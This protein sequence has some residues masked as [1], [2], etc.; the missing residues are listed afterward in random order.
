LER[1]NAVTIE[2]TC[3][4]GRVYVLPEDK[5]G[6]KLQ[7]RRCGAVIRVRRDAE[8]G[9]RV[10]FKALGIDEE[11][12]QAPGTA[13]EPP[14]PA[15]LDFK[16]PLRR[17]P[18][19]GNQD[20]PTVPVC[21]RCEYDFRAKKRRENP[22]ETRAK[23]ELNRQELR[24]DGRVARIELFSRLGFIP[25]AGIPCGLGAL[26][27]S[28]G[29]VRG[30]LAALGT[31]SR[32]AL[33]GRLDA[34]RLIAVASVLLWAGVIG[35]YAFL[36]V[37]SR[38]KQELEALALRCRTN[39][40]EIGTHVRTLRQENGRF[41]VNAKK[42]LRE[43]IE[44]VVD[45]AFLTC[46][47]GERLPYTID[48]RVKALDAGTNDEYLIVLDSEAHA[49]ASGALIWRALRADG[50]V[51]EFRSTA[52]LDKGRAR[53][54]EA[55][56]ALP[57]DQDIEGPARMSR[58]NTVVE[59]FEAH[60]DALLKL[61][62]DLDD[63]DKN[64]EFRLSAQD[65]TQ[66]V[67]LA[68][69]D[70]AGVVARRDDDA[71][72]RATARL[73]ARLDVAGPEEA[74][75]VAVLQKDADPETR[76]TLIRGLKRAEASG[77]IEA[78]SALAA[79]APQEIAD[80]A[81]ALLA[82]EAKRGKEQLRRV[83][84]QAREQRRATKTAP[85]QPIFALPA[86]TYPFAAELLDDPEV[87]DEALALLSRGG[88]EVLPA[89]EGVF[90]RGEPATRELAF[91]ALRASLVWRE[92][93]LA[94][95]HERFKWESDR[96]VKAVALM[97]LVETAD[98]E[99]VRR[100]IES[101]KEGDGT[102]NLAGVARK[103]F[104]AASGR[105]ALLELVNELE[106]PGQARDEVV[107][108]LMRPFRLL[109]E[110]VADLIAQRVPRMEGQGPHEIAIGIASAR[111][112]D[113]SHRYLLKEATQ[114]TFGT[115]RELA[116]RSL[117][118]D[119]GRLSEKVRAEVA[120]ELPIRLAKEPDGDTRTRVF[121]LIERVEFRS[122][123]G[124]AALEQVARHATESQA[125]RERALVSMALYTDPRAVTMLAELVD[126]LRESPRFVAIHELRKATGVTVD[127]QTSA[128][129]RR[130]VNQSEAEI[131]KRLKERADRDAAD[132]LARQKT[133]ESKLKELQVRAARAG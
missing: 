39:L 14:G 17:C 23:A 120:A 116:L 48:G 54:A 21:V 91:R 82:A 103:V 128:D 125:A 55:F 76:L 105:E 126:G 66:R 46:P 16:T 111:F 60:R 79:D 92:A 34:A 104:A 59:G 72:R 44:E 8:P 83:L 85:D 115:I 73:V 18:S 97:A 95:Y 15:P 30:E 62:K 52:A 19:C 113:T 107:K 49:D 99:A 4:C 114:S 5:D 36:Y 118:E 117:Q 9:V 32:K 28:L 109:E 43:G 96:A 67:G 42:T 110:L 22:T 37:P 65:F 84:V 129:W 6:R 24:Q 3:E 1:R 58:P 90:T 11:T 35:W 88:P 61:A 68:P 27:L 2:V 87:K 77:W 108:E 121:A 57:A 101:F 7:C 122:T 53:P 124:L 33:E 86:E 40:Q 38:Q 69:A 29:P 75:L 50:R 100:A 94:P 26:V 71:L 98:V 63:K 56:R 45:P 80:Q 112:D 64:L 102:D 78:A 13:R 119:S 127:E 41:P 89:L 133:H 25:I 131:K 10:P 20:E 130:V 51:E 12:A 123:A 70:A 31:P 132:M 106:R 81:L 93:S 74:R 47:L